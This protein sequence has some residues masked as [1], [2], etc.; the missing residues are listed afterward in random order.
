MR[1]SHFSAGGTGLVEGSS[2]TQA[3]KLFSMF[4][5]RRADVGQLGTNIHLLEVLTLCSDLSTY[6]CTWKWCQRAAVIIG[7][8]PIFREG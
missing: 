3:G 2:T 4:I 7:I 8:V 1:C 6:T 5:L